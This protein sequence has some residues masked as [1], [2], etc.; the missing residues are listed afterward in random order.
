MTAKAQSLA[1]ADPWMSADPLQ[2]LLQS[3]NDY[4]IFMLDATGHVRTWNAGAQN[5]KQ[6][7]AD[8]IIGQHFSIFYPEADVKAGK[9]EL[10]LVGAVEKGR[11]EDEGWRVRK[12]GTRFWANVIITPIHTPDGTLRGFAKVTRDLTERREA[13]E[14][15]RLSDQ[16]L[17]LLIEH[18]RDYAIFMLDP[19]GIVTTWNSGAQRITQF[20]AQEIIGQHFSTFYPAEVGPAH[21]KHELEIAAATGRY[22]EEGWRVRKDGSTFWASVVIGAIRDDKQQLIGFAK[23]T[24]D[25]SERKDAEKERAAR[26]AAED[27]NRVKDEFLA[28]L[29][30]ELRNPLAPTLTALQLMKLRGDIRSSKEQ[31]IIERQIKHMVRLVD[32]LLDVSRI[33]RGTIELKKQPIDLRNVIAQAIEIARPLVEQRRHSFEINGL[34]EEIT[35]LGDSVRLAQVFANLFTNAA[36]YTDPGGSIGV[37]ARTEG[38]DVVVEV[39]DNGVGISAELLP[40]VFDA[41]VQAPQTSARSAGG[42]GIGL[43]LVSSFVRLHGGVVHARSGGFGQGSVFTVRLPLFAGPASTARS[44]E[45]PS[46]DLKPIDKILRVLVVDDN[47]DALAMSADVLRMAGHDV[48]TAANGPAALKIAPEF[49]PDVAVL[50]VGLPVMDGLELADRLRVLLGSSAPRLIAV[51]GYGRTADQERTR[52]AGFDLHLVKPVDIETLT[53]SVASLKLGLGIESP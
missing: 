17:R 38:P 12:D 42:L 39:I 26:L 52:R 18:I 2:L 41:F 40:R 7:R 33:T 13:E 34:S 20:S 30:H 9:C 45:L 15:L 36:K 21:T 25:L 24:R 44:F 32:D 10:E 28:M 37:V 31:L 1:E 50:D 27:A 19:T 16:R 47:E 4:A 3:V 35:V 8:E 6:Y 23:V 29:G 22:E 5:I 14:K 53:D 43:A 11:F 46:I 51:T 49:M 48:R